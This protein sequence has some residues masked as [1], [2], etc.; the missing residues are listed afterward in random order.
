MQTEIPNELPPAPPALPEPPRGWQFDA[1]LMLGAS[2][3][4][5][6]AMGMLATQALNHYGGHWN[7]A[8]RKFG[9]F[10]I[11]N[12]FFQGALLVLTHFFL[13]RHRT[14]WGEFLGW[15]RPGLS[16]AL[17]FGVATAVLV[18]P[19]TYLLLK[20][21]E[22]FL[23]LLQETPEIQPTIQVL[24]VS[25]T[26]GQRIAFGFAAIVLAPIAEEVLF[27]GILY[28]YLKQLC[29]PHVAIIAS[30]LIFAFIHNNLMTMIPL[31]FFAVVLALLYDETDNLMAP[32]AAHALF[33]SVNFIL[34]LRQTP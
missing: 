15:N 20:M 5:S 26:V 3:M 14:T 29:H 16:R 12:V 24:Q 13:R 17:L 32:I 8:Q 31:S 19:G 10:V 34:F 27:R 33:N 9:S 23:S 30:A 21:S 22:S 4:L 6:L 1:L 18:F 2:L 7:I 11:S 25:V 28:R